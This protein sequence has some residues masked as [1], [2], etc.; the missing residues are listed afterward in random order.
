MCRALERHKAG[1]SRVIPVI[2]RPVDWKETPIGDIQALPANGKPV[3]TWRNRDEAFHNVAKGIAEVVKVL[4]FGT[5]P[6]E[7]LM[8]T[9]L[10]T[11]GHESNIDTLTINE[12]EKAILRGQ[13]LAFTYRYPSKDEEVRHVIEPQPLIQKSGHIYLLGWSIDYQMELWFRLDY[14]L[15]G[16]ATMLLTR[17]VPSRSTRRTYLLR[18]H[19]TPILARNSVSNRFPKQR[20]EHHPDGSATV[21]A[22]IDDLF[23]ARR[24][25]LHYGENCT[26]ESPPEL[27]ELIRSV[28]THYARTYFTPEE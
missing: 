2:L 19:L 1:D 13:Q 5:Q 12:I 3:T 21:I 14:I 15:P 23:A 16:T 11:L 24:T 20:V 8:S 28:A 10:S 6:T 22:Q 26:V 9:R 25:L 17:I 4:L 27:I 7:K 18:Y